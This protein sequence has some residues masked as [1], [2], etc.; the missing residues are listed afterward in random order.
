MIS[1]DIRVGRDARE[2]KT[3]NVGICNLKTAPTV[4]WTKTSPVSKYLR[5]AKS[6]GI[7]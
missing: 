1:R 3:E 7:S 2:R 4:I 6:A 5:E